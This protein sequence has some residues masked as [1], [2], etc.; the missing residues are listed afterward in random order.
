VFPLM[1]CVGKM[2]ALAIIAS[3]VLLAVALASQRAAAQDFDEATRLNEQAKELYQQGRHA[4]AESV[5]ETSS[6]RSN[7]AITISTSGNRESD[8]QSK[9]NRLNWVHTLDKSVISTPCA[10]HAT[11]AVQAT[12]G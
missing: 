9:I 2:R 6:L 11:V 5:F 7:L 3:V 10:R 12:L 8:L 1:G 4:E